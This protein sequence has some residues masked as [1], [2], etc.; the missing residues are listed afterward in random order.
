MT[1]T[2]PTNALGS[3]RGRVTDAA[4]HAV[5]ARRTE[6]GPRWSLA[7]AFDDSEFAE[8]IGAKPILTRHAA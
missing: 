2:I 3:L 4:D 7:A 6:P 5:E 1:M 8:S